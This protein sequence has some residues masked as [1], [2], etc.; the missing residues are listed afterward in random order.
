MSI[1]NILASKDNFVS[2]QKLSGKPLWVEIDENGNPQVHSTLII[3]SIENFWE[4]NVTIE[5]IRSSKEKEKKK[6]RDP[7]RWWLKK[8]KPIRH[9]WWWE[10]KK[11]PFCSVRENEWRTSSEN[12]RT[13]VKKWHIKW[14][15][16]RLSHA[17]VEPIAGN[18]VAEKHLWK[19][20]Q[21]LGWHKLFDFLPFKSQALLEASLKDVPTI[22]F[23]STDHMFGGNLM[24]HAARKGDNLLC[25]HLIRIGFG[26]LVTVQANNG[27]TAYEIA[28]FRGFPD[29]AFLLEPY[30][31][32]L[33][34]DQKRYMHEVLR[35]ELAYICNDCINN[36]EDPLPVNN[37]KNNS[38]IFP[39]FRR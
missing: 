36:K 4:Q 24:W 6:I 15:I 32:I 13:Q 16:S 28:L 18:E 29:T 38:S 1:I 26:K 39:N 12:W 30:A 20:I 8:T 7:W 23:K 14:L 27:L 10:E 19:A 3:N 21:N 11:I 35:N 33:A 31:A 9:L 5:D 25:S 2:P 22:S 37:Q 34:V 17:A